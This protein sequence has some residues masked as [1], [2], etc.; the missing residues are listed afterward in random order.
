MI[1][2]TYE[3]MEKK[4]KCKLCGSEK[5]FITYEGII[6]NGGLGKYTK[7]P[8]KMWRCE[9]CD[10]IWHDNILDVSE[11]YESKE[12]RMELEDTTEEEDFYRLHDKD[13]L[14]K[15]IY[16]GT[17]IFR[18]KKV[19]DIGCGCG[20]FLDYIKGVAEEVIAVEPSNYYLDIMRNKG[21]T[22]FQYAT[23][24]YDKLGSTVDT[25]VSFDV[26]EHVE[27]PRD[28]LKNVYNLLKEGGKAVIGTP[29]ETPV[30]RQ[31]IGEDYER[32][33]LF[34]TQHIWVLGE[35]NLR[36]ISDEI[37]F[38]SVDIKYYQR[39]GLSNLVGWVRDRV[40]GT[41]IDSSW[42]TSSLDRM[43]RSE[44]ETKGLSDYIVL[45]VEK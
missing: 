38:S 4:M 37:G 2:T 29:T 26:I 44:V 18:N 6:R 20:A 24:A 33:L 36:M 13:S 25:I 30:M 39:Y 14:D 31:L 9:D 10:A 7:S 32:K 23:D 12:Y 21:F 17:T 15:F 28:F 1:D 35:K 42:I 34:S 19:A 41:S 45:Y 22:V 5:I 11:Y 27:D 40:P 43:Y 16:T 3:E 8:V